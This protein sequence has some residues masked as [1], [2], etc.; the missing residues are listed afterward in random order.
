R[1]FLF[2]DAPRGPEELHRISGLRCVDDAIRV[3]HIF[4]VRCPVVAARANRDFAVWHDAGDDDWNDFVDEKRLLRDL[5]LRDREE[6]KREHQLSASSLFK[7]CRTA[8][9]TS[10]RSTFD[11]LNVMF[12]ENGSDLSFSVNT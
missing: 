10:L 3:R 5:E 12:S 9:I 11:F 2:R 7:S 4:R 1:N 6:R 8:S